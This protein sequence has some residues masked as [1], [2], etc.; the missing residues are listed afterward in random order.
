MS[1]G[2][3]R[4]YLAGKPGVWLTAPDDRR[5]MKE[6]IAGLADAKF[7]GAP[8]TFDRDHLR[9]ELSY[10]TRSMQFAAAVQAGI[11]AHRRR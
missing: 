9:D 10:A 4:D 3:N 5:G 2:E 11:A 8:R 1:A 6:L 7:A